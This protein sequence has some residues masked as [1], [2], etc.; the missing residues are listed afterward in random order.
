MTKQELQTLDESYRWW[1]DF[2]EARKE[3]LCAMQRL[4]MSHAEMFNQLNFNWAGQP[5][6]ILFSAKSKYEVDENV[7]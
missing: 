6:A 1:G 5:E 4:G 3:A 2:L 7:D